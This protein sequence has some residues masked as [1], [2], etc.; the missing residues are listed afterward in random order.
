MIFCVKKRAQIVPFAQKT[1]KF[2]F[3]HVYLT[4]HVIFIQNGKIWKITQFWLQTSIFY[5]KCD[6]WVKAQIVLF[7][8]NTPKL[9]FEHVERTN[10]VIMAQNGQIKLRTQFETKTR[11]FGL[12]Y[13]FLRQ[14][15]CSNRSV[16]AKNIKNYFF[17][18][19]PYQTRYFYSKRKKLDNNAI[20]AKN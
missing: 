9:N 15:T 12:K 17:T 11:I 7:E 14:R 13:D 19:L 8:L 3:L 1:S 4:K 6:F 16:C 20:L 2:T 10:Y 5:L 18:R